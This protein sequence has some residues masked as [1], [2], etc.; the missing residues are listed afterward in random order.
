M[1]HWAMINPPTELMVTPAPGTMVVTPVLT[2]E[3]SMKVTGGQATDESG[4]TVS[5]LANAAFISTMFPAS[6]SSRV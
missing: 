2:W 3:I 1:T 5:V 6:E 4:G